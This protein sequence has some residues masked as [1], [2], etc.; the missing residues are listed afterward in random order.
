MIKFK[1]ETLK[2]LENCKSCVY[3]GRGKGCT[4]CKEFI[5]KE[6][7]AEFEQSKFFKI[8]KS[9]YVCPSCSRYD[10]KDYVCRNGC[11]FMDLYYTLPKHNF[12]KAEA[13][14]ISFLS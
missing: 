1:S 10:P 12:Y 13:G 4:K 3:K 7:K 14:Q 9:F 6:T 8:A 2:H 5:V 11:G